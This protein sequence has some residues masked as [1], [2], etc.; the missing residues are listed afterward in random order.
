[1][2]DR[3]VTDILHKEYALTQVGAIA[4]FVS[5]LSTYSGLDEAREVFAEDEDLAAIPIENDDGRVFAVVTRDQIM[6]QSGSLLGALTHGSL[7]KCLSTEVIRIQAR[8]NVDRIIED[9]F[10]KQDKTVSGTLLV[11]KNSRDFLGVVSFQNLVRHS[12]QLRAR[13]LDRAR[14][15]QEFLIT[16]GTYPDPPFAAELLIRMAHEVGAIFSSF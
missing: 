2:D 4:Q 6:A 11:Y 16:S 12:A 10:V 7:Q 3:Q 8:E 15:I 14:Q 9:L 13:A 5:P 1:M